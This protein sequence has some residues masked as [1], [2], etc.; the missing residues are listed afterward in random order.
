MPGDRHVNGAMP[1][2]H[3]RD[4]EKF[5]YRERERFV[6]TEVGAWQAISR[7]E[8]LKDVC[9][10]TILCTGRSGKHRACRSGED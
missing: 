1:R 5:D 3:P 2:K 7:R 9:P 10:Q 8:A 4:S 6:L